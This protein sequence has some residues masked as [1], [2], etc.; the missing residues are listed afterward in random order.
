MILKR[1]ALNLFSLILS[2]CVGLIGL[3]Y[4]S[5]RLQVPPIAGM[6]VLISFVA[7]CLLL[8]QYFAV[9]MFPVAKNNSRRPDVPRQPWAWLRLR[10][11]NK[12]GF[13]LNKGQVLVGRDVRCEVM[14]NHHSVSR[15][16]AEVVRLAEGYLLRDLNSSNGTFVNGQRIQ[17]YL[18]QDADRLSFGDIQMTFQG[19][20]RPDVVDLDDLEDGEHLSVAQ[21]LSP[22]P[23]PLETE[24][25]GFDYGI[26]DDHDE[27]GEGGTQVWQKPEN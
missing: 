24:M 20:K 5:D 12:P 19:P 13:P 21:L 17:E 25:M 9:S 4:L 7:G 6:I 3:Q 11:E 23:L 18:M 15:K 22:E 14:L 27:V 2:S 8:S 16:H 1:W 26:N 10:G